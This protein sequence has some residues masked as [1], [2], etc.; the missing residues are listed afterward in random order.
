MT[1]NQ[2]DILSVSVSDAV[3]PAEAIGNPPEKVNPL[4]RYV[5][6]HTKLSRAVTPEDIPT[7]VKESVV[8]AELCHTAHGIYTGANAVAHAQIDDK[9]PLRFFVSSSGEI[10]INPVITNHTK[11]PVD[12]V[13]ACTSFPDK[14][15]KNVQRYHKITVKFQQLNI[16]KTLSEP[17][18][19]EFAGPESKAMQHEIAHMNGH[20]IYDE[21]VSPE[22]AL[23]EALLTATQV[24]E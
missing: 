15:P 18:E 2:P 21:V 22:D 23:G 14:P 12:S 6:W 24:K 4:L 3:K 5:P 1:E 8:L 16:D 17:R 20:S 11:T 13:E 19:E 7:V 9:D 10:I